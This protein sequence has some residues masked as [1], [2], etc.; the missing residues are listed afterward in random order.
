MFAQLAH[1]S[2]LKPIEENLR[3]TSSR[4]LKVFPKYFKKSVQSDDYSM[5][6]VKIAN[7]VYANRMGN[8]DE[9]SGD[10]W[11]FRGRGFLQLT[12]KNNYKALTLWANANGIQV[13]YVKNPDLLLIEADALISAFWYW[14]VNNLN[15]YA[16]RDG[17]LSISK[18]INL[19]NAN[20]SGIPNGMDD[21]KNQL[22]KYKKIFS[23]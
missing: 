20:E 2:G 8:G 5:Q 15:T 1:E 3:Y 18:V 10:G 4:L 23:C 21:R 7:R 17:L 13:D 12:G 14:S 9:A 16:D 6:P 11:K 22:S 19:G